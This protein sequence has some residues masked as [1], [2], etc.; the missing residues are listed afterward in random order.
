[1]ANGGTANAGGG[2]ATLF[3]NKAGTFTAPTVAT[4]TDLASG[5]IPA[6]TNAQIIVGKTGSNVQA[7]TLVGPLSITHAGVTSLSG[8]PLTSFTTQANNTVVGNVSGGAAV[9][10]ALTTAQLTTLV[11]VATTSLTGAC[12]ILPNDATKFLD[13]TGAFSV[14]SGGGGGGVTGSSSTG[15]AAMAV[16]TG[17]TSIGNVANPTSGDDVFTFTN[18]VHA[19]TFTIG[20]SFESVGILNLT[21]N[22]NRD[23]AQILMGTVSGSALTLLPAVS[24]GPNVTY[25]FPQIV[26]TEVTSQATTTARSLICDSSGNRSYVDESPPL[27]FLACE[28]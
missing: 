19:T 3:F 24:Q 12:P 16:W 22:T 6:L 5:I 15:R 13:G 21:P 26:T 27:V 2:S 25:T 1:V 7:V 18:D 17:D 23:S 28:S 10:I 8:I 9:P 20:D 14:P 11:N 4:A